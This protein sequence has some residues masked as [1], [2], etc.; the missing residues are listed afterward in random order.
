[1]ETRRSSKS[2][3]S[4]WHELQKSLEEVEVSVK[5]PICKIADRCVSFPGR[6][7]LMLLVCGWRDLPPHSASG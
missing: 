7:I 3:Q 2:P 5:H 1:M 6:S 4:C